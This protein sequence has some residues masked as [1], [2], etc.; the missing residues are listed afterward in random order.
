MFKNIFDSP[1]T[2]EVFFK[3]EDANVTRLYEG[4]LFTEWEVWT[5]E[6]KTGTQLTEGVDYLVGAQSAGATAT[7]GSAVYQGFQVLTATYH[8]VALFATI[9]WVG[10]L[11]D[12]DVVRPQT[13]YY[14]DRIESGDVL[15]YNNTPAKTTS[16]GAV[17][18]SDTVHLVDSIIWIDGVPYFNE[19]LKWP[20]RR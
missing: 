14:G 1:E 10:N 16:E 11:G 3:V 20:G 8:D 17:P 18:L 6:G 15:L 13:D 9:T 4:I 2:R 7:V 5:G 12:T 19:A